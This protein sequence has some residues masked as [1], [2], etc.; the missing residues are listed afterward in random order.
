MRLLLAVWGN[1]DSHIQYLR[2][3]DLPQL[4]QLCTRS[5]S[6]DTIG[7]EFC[8]AEQQHLLQGYPTAAAAP[9]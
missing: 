1:G 5:L 2:N 8:R 6:T 9:S 3:A 7:G 4:L